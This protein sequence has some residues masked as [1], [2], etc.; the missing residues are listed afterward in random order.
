MQAADGA[1]FKSGTGNAPRRVLLANRGK[2]AT[3]LSPSSGL[4]NG[5][6]WDLMHP[7]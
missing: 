1:K 6:A 3:Q 2:Q 7:S 4:R 5:R